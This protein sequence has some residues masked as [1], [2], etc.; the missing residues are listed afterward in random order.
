M[1]SLGDAILSKTATKLHAHFHI[2]HPRVQ[3]E[4]GRS[5]GGC[6]CPPNCPDGS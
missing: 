4:L 6:A 3:I 5:E 2:D 1:G